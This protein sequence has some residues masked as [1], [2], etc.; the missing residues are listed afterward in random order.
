MRILFLLLVLAN[1][2]FFAWSRFIA[3]GGSGADPTPLSRQ[4]EPQKLRVVP[5][6]ELARLSVPKPAP[7]APSR[8]APVVTSKCLEWGSFTPT[9]V[10]S[11]RKA[12]EPLALGERVAERKSE[13]TAAWWVF[14]PPQTGEGSARQAA[15]RK[16]GELKKLGVQDYFIVQDEGPNHWALSLGIF[17]SEEAAQARLVALRTQGV[18]S[19]RVGPRDTPVTKVW[20]Q[21]KSVDAAL[22]ARL[23]ELARQTDGSELRDCVP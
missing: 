4:I 17:R 21:V 16:A 2:A 14:I 13:E 15:L 23:Q 8:P 1:V 3:G 18:R 9:D 5:P 6:E 22:E 12:L 11:A 10:A 20:L 7:P 19:A